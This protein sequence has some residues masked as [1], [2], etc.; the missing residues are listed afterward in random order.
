MWVFIKIPPS[1]E[2]L[3]KKAGAQLHR[4]SGQWFFDDAKYQATD[5]A[6]WPRIPAPDSAFGNKA[7]ASESC[8]F[9]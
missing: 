1:E 5:F 3:A 2:S 7:I 8:V 6:R 4:K 9:R